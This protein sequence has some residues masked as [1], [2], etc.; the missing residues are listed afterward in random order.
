MRHA[1]M[2]CFVSPCWQR[3]STSASKHLPLSLHARDTSNVYPFKRLILITQQ[4]LIITGEPSPIAL[5]AT[6]TRLLQVVA[7]SLFTKRALDG[8]GRY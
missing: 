4:L 5:K 3:V 2:V 6:T 7:S 8:L 1:L